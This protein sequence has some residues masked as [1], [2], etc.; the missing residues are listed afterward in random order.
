MGISI[1]DSIKNRIDLGNVDFAEIK[2]TI[3]GHCQNLTSRLMQADR[4]TLLQALGVV[5]GIYCFIFLCV[6]LFSGSTIKK[7]EDRMAQESVELTQGEVLEHSKM[8]AQYYADANLV[9]GLSKLEDIGRL[10]VIRPHDQFTSFRAYQIPFE[11]QGYDQ[12]TF[13]S[14]MLKN[15][16]LSKTNSEMALEILPPE[17]SF[18]L[19]PYA[20]QPME[21]VKRARTKGHEVWL[22]IPV[23]SNTYPDSGLNTIF[24]HQNLSEKSELLHGSLTSALGYVGVAMYLDDSIQPVED[25]YKKISDELYGRGLGVFEKNPQAPQV[26]ESIAV[27]RGAPFIKADLEVF[28]MKGQNSFVALEAIAR[29]KKHAVATIPPYPTVMKYLAMWIE[30]AG[31]ADYAVAPVSAIYDLPIERNSAKQADAP[32]GLHPTDHAAQPLSLI[33]I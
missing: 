19:S 27:A 31:R 6:Y 15:F 5:V 8:N 18:L 29:K 2:K 22:D 10:P 1:P 14:F 24:H 25:H 11:F 21:W 3:T 7:L 4:K 16:G 23:Q 17:V 9:E 20:Q 12:R 28:Q 33:H 30:K 26:I 13:I 32:S